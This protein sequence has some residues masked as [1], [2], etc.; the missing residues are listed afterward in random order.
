MFILHAMCHSEVSMLAR[1]D[2]STLSEQVC[3]E[4]FIAR[5]RNPVVFRG[6]NGSFRDVHTWEGVSLDEKGRVTSI[7]WD[8][9]TGMN[10]VNLDDTEST[11]GAAVSSGCVDLEWLPA[12]LRHLVLF[13]LELGGEVNTYLLPQ[14]LET[15]NIG[16]NAF[17]STFD[18]RELPPSMVDIH[19]EGNQLFG[20]LDLAN[21]PPSLRKFCAMWNYF[22]GSA[23]LSNLPRTLKLLCLEHNQLVGEIHFDALPPALCRVSLYSNRF[24]QA[25]F[26][27]KEIPLSLEGIYIDAFVAQYHTLQDGS[28]VDKDYI[29]IIF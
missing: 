12:H 24:T 21:L 5:L 13:F 2:K 26:H 23:D 1:A 18:T 7:F 8:E 20:G 22:T 15:F 4:L 28:S 19:I 14:Q 27:F 9:N 25:F 29:K 17:Q 16:G 10:Y 6:A 11:S 3:M